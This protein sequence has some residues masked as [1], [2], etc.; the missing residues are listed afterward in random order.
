MSNGGSG[1]STRRLE[2]LK[3]PNLYLAFELDVFGLKLLSLVAQTLDLSNAV[4]V[5]LRRVDFAV[6]LLIRRQ[7]LMG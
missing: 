6:N 5:Q 1:C 2:A 7:F 4:R 3:H